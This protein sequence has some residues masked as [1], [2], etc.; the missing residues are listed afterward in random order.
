MSFLNLNSPQ[1]SLELMQF[2]DKGRDGIKNVDQLIALL[3][4]LLLL[5]FSMHHCICDQLQIEELLNS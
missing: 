1:Q 3:L 5:V 2:F 4:T